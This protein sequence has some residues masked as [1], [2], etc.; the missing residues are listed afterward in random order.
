MAGSNA[1]ALVM[2]QELRSVPTPPT[3]CDDLEEAIRKQA[4]KKQRDETARLS[5][6]EAED[7]HCLVPSLSVDLEE[8][9][10]A[11]KGKGK[12]GKGK[13]SGGARGGGAGAKKSKDD[14]VP[15]ELWYSI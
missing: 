11:E 10:E 12:K 13:K 4:A 2:A 5:I 9:V 6:F 7:C 14:D 1:P 3:F 15:E 8:C